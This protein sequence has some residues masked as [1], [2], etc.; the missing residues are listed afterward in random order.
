MPSFTLAMFGH[1]FIPT[2]GAEMSD[3]VPWLILAA[4]V[5]GVFV[6]WRLDHAVSHHATPIS[7]VLP[8]WNGGPGIA[9]QWSH[10]KDR[11]CIRG[12]GKCTKDYFPPLRFSSG[13]CR[14]GNCVCEELTEFVPD[15][16]D[17]LSWLGKPD[18]WGTLVEWS[19]ERGEWRKVAGMNSTSRWGS[20]T[21]VCK[22]PPNT[23]TADAPACGSDPVSATRALTATNANE[24]G[25][26]HA[27]E[28]HGESVR[29]D[30][31]YSGSGALS[32]N[33]PARVH[34]LYWDGNRVTSVV[35]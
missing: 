25:S 33:T 34:C 16:P 15:V 23:P 14:P 1:D 8:V 28:L 30:I 35:L 21:K 5:A 12:D 4:L 13:C 29:A 31:M 20:I 24:P 32:I 11:E 2:I 19:Y 18:P 26:P 7:G 17:R 6:T 27:F 3:R 22:W 9:P 10:C